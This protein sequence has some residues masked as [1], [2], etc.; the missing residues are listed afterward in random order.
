MGDHQKLQLNELNELRDQSYKNSLIYKEKTKKLHESKIKNRIFNVGDRVLPFNSRLKA[1]MEDQPLPTDALPIALLPGYIDDSNPEEDEEDP[2]E[3]PETMI[4]VNQ[5]MS[6][7]EIE[8]V[9]AQRVANAIEAIAIYEMKTNIALKSMSQTERQKETVAENA[10]NK[11]KWESNHNGS[12]S[13]Q[14]KGHKV[15]RA[16]TS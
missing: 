8:L 15:P 5:G 9:V 16:H 10:S 13:Q 6:I 14:K 3:D 4:T 1:P 11:R 12:L 7:E 2:E